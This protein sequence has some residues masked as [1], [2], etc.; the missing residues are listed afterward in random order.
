[1]AKA[2][3]CYPFLVRKRRSRPGILLAAL[4]VAVAAGL[5]GPAALAAQKPAAAHGFLVAAPGQDGSFARTVIFL[6]DHDSQGALGLIINLPSKMPLA[7]ALPDLAELRGRRDVV[8]AGGP[9]GLDELRALIRSKAAPPEAVPLI[10]GVYASGSRD[11]IRAV[12]GG[13]LP[14]S[15]FRAYAGYAGW[16]PG[17]LEAE[18]A[19]RIWRVLP[20][21]ADEIFTSHPDRLW[22]ELYDRTQGVLVELAPG[23][24]GA[25]TT[26]VLSPPALEGPGAGP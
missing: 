4:L 17:Q 2:G 24:G 21:S 25:G 3:A 14:G 22:K 5:A 11:T 12:A 19:R 23:A 9:V 8:Y 6:I 26:H 20:A 1:V 16:A 18:I 7:E 13:K 10:D 15:S